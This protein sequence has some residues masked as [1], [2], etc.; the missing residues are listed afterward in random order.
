MVLLDGRL[1]IPK[2]SRRWAAIAS[3]GDPGHLRSGTRVERVRNAAATV[4]Y[5]VKKV[6]DPQKRVQ[7]QYQNV[8]KLWGAFGGVK[9]EPV[10][11]LQ[12]SR[13]ELAPLV[14]GLRHLENSRR[15]C[16]ALGSGKPV[17]TLRDNG[18]GGW[19]AHGLAPAAGRCLERLAPQLLNQA[20]AQP[21]T[22]RSSLKGGPKRNGGGPS[23]HGRIRPPRLADWELLEPWLLAQG[24]CLEAVITARCP[25]R[26]RQRDLADGPC[27]L[28]GLRVDRLRSAVNRLTARAGGGATWLPRAGRPPPELGV[29]SGVS[30]ARWRRSSLS[31]RR[32]TAKSGV[33]FALPLV[34]NRGAIDRK[35]G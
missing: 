20:L 26:P 12:G 30:R 4:N 18:V 10:R 1:D 25:A 7:E 24:R 35:W 16:R 11:T 8:G 14:R 19:T 23:A 5:M 22:S 9:A 33:L 32:R 15:R 13:E 21:R 27:G 28:P 17:P 2:V 29:R 3:G 6:D 31:R 34:P